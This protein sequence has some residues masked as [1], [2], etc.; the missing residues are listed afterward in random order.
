MICVNYANKG[1]VV[2]IRLTS[3]FATLQT[4]LRYYVSNRKRRSNRSRHA[5]AFA[6]AFIDLSAEPCYAAVTETRGAAGKAADTT[7][8]EIQRMEITATRGVAPPEETNYTS[9]A[10]ARSFD[11]P[12]ALT[13]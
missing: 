5:A 13:F 9:V 4:L 1:H 12:N 6:A 2:N 10:R 11:G 7:T 3:P 8:G